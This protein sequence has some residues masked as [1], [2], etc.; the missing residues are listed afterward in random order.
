[1]KSHGVLI[2]IT[3]TVPELQNSIVTIQERKFGGTIVHP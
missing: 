1:M 3:D 2:E